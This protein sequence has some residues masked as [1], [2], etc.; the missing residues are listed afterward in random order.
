LKKSILVPTQVLLLKDLDV[1]VWCHEFQ[2]FEANVFHV[3]IFWSYFIKFWF[4]GFSRK[5]K[6]WK[7][8][9]KDKKFT[10]KEKFLKDPTP[11]KL[12]GSFTFL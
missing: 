5:K 2:G 10:R 12:S 11:Y 6:V 7:T 3:H 1:V 4:G 9:I 8:K